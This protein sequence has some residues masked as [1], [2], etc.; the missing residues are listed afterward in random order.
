MTGPGAEAVQQTKIVR[1]E[2]VTRSYGSG[3]TE[4]HALRGVSITI[5]RGELWRCAGGRDL[6]RPPC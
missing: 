1:V 5:T 2:E 6:G 4:V 3:A